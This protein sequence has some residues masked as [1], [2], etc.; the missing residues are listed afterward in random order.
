MYGLRRNDA[1][2]HSYFTP[3]VPL[4]TAHFHS[5]SALDPSTLTSPSCYPLPSHPSVLIYKDSPTH[6]QLHCTG[7]RHCSGL[8]LTV[9]LLP[10]HDL[11]S[12][13]L[14]FLALAPTRDCLTLDCQLDRCPPLV[15][16]LVVKKYQARMKKNVA[17]LKLFTNVCRPASL[18]LPPHL[19]L[20]ADTAEGAEA[21]LGGEAGGAGGVLMKWG[22]RVVLLHVSDQAMASPVS[23]NRKVMHLKMY[24]GGGK[25]KGGGGGGEEAEVAL[26]SWMCGLIDRVATA[27][28]SSGA[29]DKAMALRKRAEEMEAKEKEKEKEKEREK[30]PMSKRK[31]EKL[32]AKAKK[33]K[34]KLIK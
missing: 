13:L 30:K 28:L 24:V 18:Q 2:A 34:I 14:S 25:G 17:D 6:Y 12:L 19:T 3:L 9:E 5:L 15:V 4:L 32:A 20:M 7:R 26:V 23:Q 1:I 16:A 27:T 33:P 21:V 29:Y 11:F 10:R 8:L 31:E 22:E